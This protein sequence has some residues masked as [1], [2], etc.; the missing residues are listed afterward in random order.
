MKPQTYSRF[1]K[2][3]A[4]YMQAEYPQAWAAVAA[5]D[6]ASRAAAAVALACFT[7]SSS[8]P[9]TAGEIA[10]VVEQLASE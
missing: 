4:W 3:V 8:I 5:S 10:Q 9:N 7:S 1:A 6:E 2:T